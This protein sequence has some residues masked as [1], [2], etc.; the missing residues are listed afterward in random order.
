[1]LFATVYGTLKF[2]HPRGY[3][4]VTDITI[5][6]YFSIFIYGSSKRNNYTCLNFRNIVPADTAFEFIVKKLELYFSKTSVYYC[7]L[8]LRT[9]RP[10]QTVFQF[11]IPSLKLL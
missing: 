10:K 3:S 6:G 1:M 8:P 11:V 9:L 2:K 5:T 7:D 4:T